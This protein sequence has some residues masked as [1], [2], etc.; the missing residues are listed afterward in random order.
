M[1]TLVLN[2][3]GNLL[4][5]GQTTVDSTPTET[6]P[7]GPTTARWEPEPV[8]HSTDSVFLNL[9]SM[10]VGKPYPVTLGGVALV[11]V[12]EPDDSVSFYALS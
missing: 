1:S 6:T 11:A 9:G 10:H 7:V 5:P 3:P 8:I 4:K 12:K 2:R